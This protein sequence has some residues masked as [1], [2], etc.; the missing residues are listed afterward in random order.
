MDADWYYF[1]INNQKMI[2]VLILRGK[3]AKLI[4]VPFFEVTL[5]A[6]TKVSLYHFLS[7]TTLNLVHRCFFYLLD[8]E[9]RWIIHNI[10]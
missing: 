4:K 3:Q 2:A 6:Y 9:H 7:I 10:T 8:Y 1:D 5:N